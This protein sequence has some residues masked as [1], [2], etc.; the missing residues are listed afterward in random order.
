MSSIYHL[1]KGFGGGRNYEWGIYLTGGRKTVS[2]YLV[3]PNNT[4]K[5]VGK[6]GDLENND[7]PL[8]CRYVLRKSVKFYTDGE[9]ADKIPTAKISEG[10]VLILA[11]VF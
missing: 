9:Q 10:S 5:W 8:Y 3:E 7:W 4:V 11:P 6:N 1:P 2:M